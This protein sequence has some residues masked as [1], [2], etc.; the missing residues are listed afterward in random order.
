MRRFLQ[1]ALMLLAVTLPFTAGATR[2]MSIS[3]SIC[4]DGVTKFFYGSDGQVTD[5]RANVTITNTGDEALNVGDED[6]TFTINYYYSY[7]S[8]G[9]PTP[10]YTYGP[11]PIP[12]ALAVGESKT[13]EYTVPAFNGPE[14]Y[15]NSYGGAKRWNIVENVSGKSTQFA[16]TNNITIM[17]KTTA[18]TLTKNGQ[19]DPL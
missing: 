17:P 10:T 4:D 8:W 1:S 14:V 6:Y 13:F 9:T 19:Y 5:L 16:G 11:F 2:S 12:E 18:T 15:S 7:S 3:S